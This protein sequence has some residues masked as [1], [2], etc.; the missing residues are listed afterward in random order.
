M[1]QM[2]HVLVNNGVGVGTELWIPPMEN[3]RPGSGWVF[4]TGVSHLLWN[5]IDLSAETYYRN[6]R[7]QV[8]YKQG[9]SFY[10]T[11][12]TWK[13]QVVQGDGQAYGL[14]L[15]ARKT[16]GKIR[17]SL[18]YGLSRSERQFDALN[19]GKKFL[20]KFDR[21]HNAAATLIF[22][23]PL[24]TELQTAWT[25]FSGSMVTTPSYSFLTRPWSPLLF[26]NP[27][28]ATA[29][30]F[31]QRNN[32]RLPFYHRLDISFAARPRIKSLEFTL[33]AG[34]YNVLD[35]QNAVFARYEYDASRYGIRHLP[36][37]PRIPYFTI[38]MRY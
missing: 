24:N 31:P 36:L 1:Q 23:L 17:G 27:V 9:A 21:T 7:H 29:Y 10:S 22:S 15:F 14:E 12:E 38:G 37:Y 3:I 20:F 2:L 11:S 33:Q 35:R 6:M 25:G 19:R 16:T 8:D 32:Y 28:G 13:N 5:S 4:T 34:F 18:S 30:H 26:S